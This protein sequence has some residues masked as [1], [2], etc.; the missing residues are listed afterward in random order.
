MSEEELMRS[1]KGG[2]LIGVKCMDKNDRGFTPI[3]LTF[4]DEELPKKV[5]LGYMSYSVRSYER[6]PLRCFKCQ[7]F[8]HIGVCRERRRCRWCS[9]D[10]DGKECKE[11]A[12]CCNC[13]GNNPAL[14]RGC[15]YYQKAENVQKV[16]K[17]NKVSYAEAE[18]RVEDTSRV[19]Q[20]RAEFINER[21]IK[22]G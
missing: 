22:E 19:G 1:L 7:K 16:R 12:K 5:M 13:G 14:Y 15:I 20:V 21:Q 18:R 3:L 4:K 17:E 10:H 9:G 6:P 11:T 8:E 2:N